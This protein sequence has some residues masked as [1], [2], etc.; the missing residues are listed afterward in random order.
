MVKILPNFGQA[1]PWANHDW[2]PEGFSG[3]SISEKDRLN[4]K[5]RIKAR[6]LWNR[7]NINKLFVK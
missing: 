2:V 4:D 3:K 5:R 7:R 1:Q 6:E